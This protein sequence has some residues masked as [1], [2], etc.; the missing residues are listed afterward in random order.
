MPS[1]SRVLPI[2]IENE[3][4]NSRRLAC[5]AQ[6]EGRARGEA[7]G[8][9]GDESV[10]LAC[11]HDAIDEP[12]LGRFL[13][14]DDVGEERQLLG[15]VHADEAGQEPTNS[16]KLG[17]VSPAGAK[18]SLEKRA[19]SEATIRSQPRARFMPAPTATPFTLAMMGL[20][21]MRWSARAM[22]ATQCS[23][24]IAWRVS[25]PRSERSAPEQNASPARR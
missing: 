10:E 14:G 6:G 25:P 21:E 12:H 2:V 22:S 5:A 3:F 11:R 1:A 15:A 7:L 9:V 18:I 19:C 17:T 4:D 24:C 13:R 8:P 20:G 23:R 16:S